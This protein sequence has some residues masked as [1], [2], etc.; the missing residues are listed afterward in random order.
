[1]TEN[2]YLNREQAAEY[3]H[4]SVSTLNQWATETPPRIKMYK[5]GSRVLYK[6]SDL[7]EF[8]ESGKISGV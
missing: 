1:M 6:K 8:V 7:D 2:P 4:L 3:L 5:V